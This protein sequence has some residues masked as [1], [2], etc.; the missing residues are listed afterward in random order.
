MR[1]R[2]CHSSSLLPVT[3]RYTDFQNGTTIT[4][5]NVTLVALHSV[6]IPV[7]FNADVVLTCGLS[8]CLMYNIQAFARIPTDIAGILINPPIL[9]TLLAASDL[10]KDGNLPVEREESFG[11]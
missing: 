3:G 11:A 6:A 9:P 10:Y 7:T 1:F 8:N 4:N 2:P 5:T